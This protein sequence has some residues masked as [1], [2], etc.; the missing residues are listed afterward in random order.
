M[1]EILDSMY[2]QG[3]YEERNRMLAI[4]G[5]ILQIIVSIGTV[6]RDAELRAQYKASP[7]VQDFHY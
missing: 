3:V 4:A 1:P 5:N 6:G 7:F 2:A